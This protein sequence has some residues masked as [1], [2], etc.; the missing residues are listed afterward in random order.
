MK[1]KIYKLFGLLSVALLL[2]G[3]G[4]KKVITCTQEETYTSGQITKV[5]EKIEITLD[6][7]G[8]I[9]AGKFSSSATLS[10]ELTDE[11]IEEVKSAADQQCEGD[12]YSDCKVTRN[13]NVLTISAVASE[14]SVKEENET[15]QAAYKDAVENDDYKDGIENF[16]IK[17]YSSQSS[18]M[19]CK[20]K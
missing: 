7:G 2:T 4:G 10:D 17:Q 13:G 19:T 12:D 15:T 8:N 1:E 11:E 3:C 14:S 18:E 16:I 5:E 9:T 20:I 6:K